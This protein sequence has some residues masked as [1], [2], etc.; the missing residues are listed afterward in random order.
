MVGEL[1]STLQAAKQAVLEPFN[2]NQ[3]LYDWILHLP[4][5]VK[6]QIAQRY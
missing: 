4:V 5:L 3:S 2:N 6:F 1:Q